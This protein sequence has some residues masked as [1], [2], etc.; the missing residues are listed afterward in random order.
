M[1]ARTTIAR[2]LPLVDGALLV[3]GGQAPTLLEPVDTALDHVAPGHPGAQLP[4][5]AVDDLAV[6]PLLAPYPRLRFASSSGAMAAQGRIGQFSTFHQR[7]R[8]LL[9]LGGTL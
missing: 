4:Q 7:V 1:E 5:D 2:S 6:I 3:A 8:L 9:C